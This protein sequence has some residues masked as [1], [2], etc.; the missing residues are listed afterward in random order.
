MR[1]KV[2]TNHRD[3]KIY[4]IAAESCGVRA[5]CFYF[6]SPD[7][8]ILLDPGCALGPF[9][10]NRMPHPFEFQRQRKLTE[11]IMRIAID[12]DMLFISHYHH[13]HFKPNLRDDYYVYS[14]EKIFETIARDKII[15]AKDPECNI[16]YNQQKRGQKYFRDCK[17]AG[18]TILSPRSTNDIVNHRFE[19]RINFQH[20]K[21]RY[22]EIKRCLLG[23][24][25]TGNTDI[26]LPREF[27]HGLRP[28]KKIYL[29]PVIIR[30]K[31]TAFY[32]FPDVQ[33][34]PDEENLEML[35]ETRNNLQKNGVDQHLIAFGGPIPYIYRRRTDRAS[36]IILANSISHSCRVIKAFDIS[37]ID[38]HIL[39][40]LNYLK[41]WRQFSYAASAS[42]HI[43]RA[44][45]TSLRFD[46]EKGQAGRTNAVMEVNRTKLYKNNP[47]SHEFNI[48]A[49]RAQRKNTRSAPPPK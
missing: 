10:K 20:V 7:L 47:S 22:T 17:R 38:H 41:Y 14:N 49:K 9:K 18:A 1:N 29:Q 2:I 19:G 32:F 24:I 31:N 5:F 25:C 26:L 35:M 6:H 4:P 23:T 13:D 12:A 21:N 27:L 46:N 3:F 36:Q 8:K 43:V 34:F 33:G 28:K 15:L 39:R 45:N 30:R 37:I 11:S 16:N 48:W 42:D 44:V 40:D